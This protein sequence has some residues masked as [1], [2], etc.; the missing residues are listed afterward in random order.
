MTIGLTMKPLAAPPT[1]IKLVGVCA[2]GKSTLRQRLRAAGFDA[3][4]CAQEH[5]YVPDLWRRLNPPDVLI[6]LDAQPPTV[7]RRRQTSEPVEE[8][9]ADERV[10]LAH[11]RTHCDLYLP[12]DDLT[13]DQVEAA[14]LAFLDAI[15]A[16]RLRQGF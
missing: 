9:L 7:A 4:S 1:R 13:P 14:A 12:T 5:S 10:R 15:G 8:W 6:F 2:S 3:A 11:A 16:Q